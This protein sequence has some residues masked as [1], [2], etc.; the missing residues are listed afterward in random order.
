LEAPPEPTPAALTCTAV[1]I[2]NQFESKPLSGLADAASHLVANSDELVEPKPKACILADPETTV[3]DTAAAVCSSLPATSVEH[4]FKDLVKRKRLR[5][6]YLSPEPATA[7]AARGSTTSPASHVTNK[8]AAKAARDQDRGSDRMV[9]R[10]VRRRAEWL[11]DLNTDRTS[12]VSVSMPAVDWHTHQGTEVYTLRHRKK[13]CYADSDLDGRRDARSMDATGASK[14]DGKIGF[15][16]GMPMYQLLRHSENV[17]R[18]VKGARKYEHNA[19]F[20]LW[21][22]NR[23]AAKSDDMYGLSAALD[24]CARRYCDS[25]SCAVV[26]SDSIHTD[27]QLSGMLISLH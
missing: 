2:D 3:M 19:R 10:A 25:N 15:S 21:R 12:P 9:S 6:P 27:E 16:F 8:V 24:V 17:A 7:Q 20:P 26:P 1:A 22:A 23:S 4:G 11:L 18:Q 13:V 5:Q 14:R